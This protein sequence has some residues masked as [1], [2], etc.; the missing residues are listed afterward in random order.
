MKLKKYIYGAVV[1]AM[2][3][4]VSGCSGWLDY[5]PKDKQIEAQQ[6]G[7]RQGFYAAVNGA[8]N[9]LTSD[10]M[11]GRNL[12]FGMLD[13]MAKRY[14]TGD[15]DSR[16]EYKYAQ[17]NY[18]DDDVAKVLGNIWDEVY[19]EILNVNVILYN[20]EEQK[21]N[22][23][24]MDYNMMKGDLLALRAFLHFD[25]LRLFGPVYSRNP[26]MVCIPYNESNEAKTYE[27][28]TAKSVVFDHLL[29][30]LENAEAALK[31]SDPVLTDGALASDSEDGDNYL[32]YRQL[33]LNYY[34]VALL[35]AR[36]YLWVGDKENA[37]IE[38]RKITDDEKVKS[39]FPFVDPDKLL[40]NTV[41]PDRTF[42]TEV[43]F[44]FYK[45]SRNLIYTSYFDGANL[46]ASSL[47]QPR[48][49]YIDNLY[50][51]ADYRVLSQWGSYGSVFNFVKYKAIT[52]EKDEKVPFYAYFMPLMRLS[53]AYYI[54]A[55]A[56]LDT[57]M[58]ASRVYLNTILAKRGALLLGEEVTATTLNNE[59]LKEYMRETWGEG[60]IFYL[61]KRRY[62]SMTADY[63][64]ESQSS[65]YASNAIFVLPLPKSENE[66]R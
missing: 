1:F 34:S 17:H 9:R 4:L 49:S 31:T 62:Q 24:E 21:E 25:M 35:K 5:T 60:Q 27:L 29:P 66:N 13:L 2:A 37:A 61:L 18:T 6:F 12:S 23:T 20:L 7:S 50:S 42:S 44:G 14:N 28:L 11:Y 53:E 30:D 54:A 46:S 36:V 10:L 8:Y 59:I 39:F 57:D 45:S 58:D 56:L 43:L 40:G 3:G 52:I 38:A 32:R 48:A 16:L 64:A 51:M 63:N 26:E 65:V 19:A 47:L 15:T 33:R 41:K 55:E 22:L